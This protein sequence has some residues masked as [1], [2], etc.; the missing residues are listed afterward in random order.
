MFKLNH[1]FNTTLYKREMGGS[2]RM[3]LIF[4]GIIA[5]YAG[6]VISMYEPGIEGMLAQLAEAIPELMAAVGM[7]GAPSDLTGFI[8]SYL[9]GMLLLVFPMVYT[10]LR[11]NALVARYVDRGSMAGL[12]AAP[13]KRRSIAL[14]QAGALA[15]GI[16]IMIAFITILEA[17]VSEALFPGELDIGGIIALNSGLLC[18]H[19]FIGGICFLCSCIFS[20]A[21][22]SAGLGAGIPAFMYILLMISN[23]G[24]AAEN[25]KYATF[26]TL[27]NTEAILA[28]DPSGAA[29]AAILLAGAVPLFASGIT[30]FSRKDLHV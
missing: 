15:T 9:Y 1:I 30:V 21:K 4:A 25:V 12:L 7:G 23:I 3:L 5:M 27:Y 20:D 22:H 17:A 28:G 26:F 19:L 8:S 18:L 6:V 24:G 2:W 10:I 16:I 11:A 14:T 13:V 29:G